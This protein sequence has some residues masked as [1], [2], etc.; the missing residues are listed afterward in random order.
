MPR[1]ATTPLYISEFRNLW[2]A[3]VVSNLG[4]FLQAV[5]AA[6]LML[7]LTGSPLW[8][9]LMVA[10]PTLPLLVLAMPAGAM[11]DLLDRRRIMLVAH[12]LMAVSAL[13]LAALSLTDTLTPGLL[14]GF[15]LLLGIG[16]AFNLPAWQAMVPDLVP[17]Q[18]VASAVALNSAAFNVAR[19]VGPALGGLLL[20]TVGPGPA[21]AANAV[22]YLAVM[23]AVAAFPKPALEERADSIM[24]AIGSGLRYARFTPSYRWLLLVAA[25]FALTSAVLQSVL[26]NFTEDVLGGDAATYG[27]LL[28]AMGVGAL[29]GAFTRPAAA[30][31]LSKRMVPASISA[32]GVAG[33]A[34]GL[35]PTIPVAAAAMAV[36]GVLWVWILATLNATAQLLSPAWVRGRIMSLYT[37]AFLGC[38]PLGAIL[39][40]GLADI[41]GSAGA[42]VALSS[43]SVAL[44]LV[45]SRLPLPVLD[46]VVTPVPDANYEPEPH[47]LGVEGGPV[48]VVN[49]WV[50]DE[51]DL[52]PFLLVMDQVRRVRLRTGAYR[53]RLYR[54]VGDAHRMTEVFL[55]TSWQQHLRQHHRIDTQAA[56][57]IIRAR[58]FD[59]AGGPVTHHLAA[60]DVTSSALPDWDDLVA[61]DAMHEEDG[62]VPLPAPER[63]RP[64][65]RVHGRRRRKALLGG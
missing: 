60:I 9:G 5:A 50:I 21:F 8:V 23:A 10:A 48:M 15:G 16:S 7:E 61:H 62:S 53:W 25:L 47:V 33:V 19:A 3:S 12:G 64:P 42:I 45:V 49:T 57:T 20:V 44:G 4:S 26:P 54:N 1:A 35:A 37:L 32:F 52:N 40:G 17:N 51:A 29:G 38:L 46:Q 30:A 6:W 39:A 14:L 65:A 34:L 58:A 63:P 18:Y 55:L 13:A 43:G 2:L 41:I 31:R 27:L 36:A 28:G 24:G 56:A 22:S 11:A 59:R